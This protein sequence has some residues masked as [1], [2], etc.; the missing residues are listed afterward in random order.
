EEAAGVDA[1]RIAL[2]RIEASQSDIALVGGAYNGERRDL[3]LLYALG[4]HSLKDGYAPVW[5]RAARGGGM[6]LGSLGAFLVLESREHAQARNATPLA[7]L[8]KV[9]SDRSN[10]EGAATTAALVRMWQA[11]RPT[12]GRVAVISG[13]TGT[14]PATTLERDWL[15]TLPGVAVRAT[16][17]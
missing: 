17:T 15:A 6:A 7:R 8:S 4:G 14:E 11:L 3:I 13:A 10:R 1:V 12:P 2:A 9:V 16:G 5:E